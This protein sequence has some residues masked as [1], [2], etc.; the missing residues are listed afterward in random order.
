M[1]FLHTDQ[2][3]LSCEIGANL[4]AAQDEG[5]LTDSNVAAADTL[6]GVRLL[7]TGGHGDQ[8][9]NQYRFQRAIDLGGYSSELTDALI[10]PLTTVVGLIALTQVGASERHQMI[11]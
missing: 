10:A 9:P 3:R 4:R 2:L 11:Q 6:A 7:P 1:P 5:Y 8:Q